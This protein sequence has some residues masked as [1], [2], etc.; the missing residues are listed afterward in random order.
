MIELDKHI[1]HLLLQSDCVIVPGLGGFVASH[2]TAWYD[3]NDNMFIPPYR[4]LGFNPKLNINDSL[5]AQSYTETYDISYPEAYNRIEREVEELKQHIA[6]NGSY[7]LNDIGTLYLNDDGNIEFTPC[8]AG[9]LT[10]GL[11]SFSSFEMAMLAQ[12]EEE[13]DEATT[14]GGDL[15]V[16]NTLLKERSG[17][18]DNEHI[19]AGRGKLI[20][21]SAI[22]NLVAAV[23]AVFLFFAL[24]TP[25]NEHSNVITSNMDGGLIQQLIQN[26]YKSIKE[27]GNRPKLTVPSKTTNKD[28]R[29]N[30]ECDNAARPKAK[31][32][33]NAL[34]EV[35]K[36][37]QNQYYCLVLASRVAK[38]NALSFVKE[39]KQKGFNEAEMLTENNKSTKVVYGH[40]M[41]QNE[42][43]NSLNKL[44]DTEYFHDAWVYQV[45]D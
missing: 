4:T 8:E 23:I 35:E 29:T 7:E 26:G 21:L 27:T 30:E 24:G 14:S 42:A 36:G 19:G 5:L 28:N 44:K 10:P 34:T 22:R 20:K 3:H 43:F 17:I 32:H 45:K 40:Y 16:P 6:N 18:T 15:Y 13:D 25:V 41:T 11:Y 33:P 39:L 9:I 2:V 37:Q 1:E 12:S 31:P 38:A